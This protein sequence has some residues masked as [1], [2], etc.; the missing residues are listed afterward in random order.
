MIDAQHF[1]QQITQQA[2]AGTPTLADTY[3]FYGQTHNKLL[4]VPLILLTP[5]YFTD[6]H[7][8]YRKKML[9]Y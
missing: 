8:F 5:I 7:L 3:L 6:K 4:P 1:T 2:T 9:K